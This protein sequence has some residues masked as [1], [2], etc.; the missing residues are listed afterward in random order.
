MGR[1]MYSKGCTIDDLV[2]SEMGCNPNKDD[3]V[4]KLVTYGCVLF[5][6]EEIVRILDSGGK[7]HLDNYNGRDLLY[8]LL[9]WACGGQGPR[10][11]DPPPLPYA[12]LGPWSV[13][14]QCVWDP[15]SFGVVAGFV[16]CCTGGLGGGGESW[17]WNELVNC[18]CISQLAQ[19]A[20][21]LLVPETKDAA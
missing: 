11:V 17:E 9:Q 19:Y 3:T 10:S 18:T 2:R 15:C 6:K 21:S 16:S 5:L 1:W 12:S 13:V 20:D 7:L 14:E 4:D 8:T